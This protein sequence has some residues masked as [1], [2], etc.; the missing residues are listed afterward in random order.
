MSYSDISAACSI[1]GIGDAAAVG[2]ATPTLSAICL[3]ISERLSTF[4]L[5]SIMGS[6]V[7]PAGGIASATG[8]NVAI[9][10]GGSGG[11]Y[12]RKRLTTAFSGAAY[13]VGA[14]GTGGSAGNNAGNNGTST[15]FTAT[16]GGGTVYTGAL[17][18]GGGGSAG[19]APGGFSAS[20]AGGA[21]TNGDINI[22]GGPSTWGMAITHFQVL[23][24]TG[25]NS[26]YGTGGI[27]GQ[28]FT[29]GQSAAG[30]AATGKGAGGGGA[31]GSDSAASMAGGD[32]TDGIL[33]IYEYS[34]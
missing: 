8:S 31:V 14:K 13:V 26:P 28:V 30:A 6:P 19:F 27:G 33:I 18:T 2:A 24:A 21:G 29:N 15:T 20:V 7:P 9:A 10:G 11:G 23:G 34:V 25:G 3:T 17:G 1:G 16:G 32:G 12:F 22:K 4:W 5:R